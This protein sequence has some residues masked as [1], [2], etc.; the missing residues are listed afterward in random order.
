MPRTDVAGRLAASC[1]DARPSTPGQAG[2]SDDL[3]L[4]LTFPDEGG[5][6]EV[7]VSVRYEDGDGAPALVRVAVFSP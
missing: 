5:T 7:T 4:D 6:D 3:C 1:P 2:R